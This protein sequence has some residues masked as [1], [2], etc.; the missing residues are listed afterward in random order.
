MKTWKKYCIGLAASASMAPAVLAQVP[1]AGAAAAATGV[2]AAPATKTL[3]SFL[4][5][6]KDQLGA[7]KEKLCQ[8][9]MGQMMGNG[10]KPMSALTGGVIPSFCPQVPSAADLAKPGAE[11]VAAKIKKEEAEAKARRAAVRYLGSVDCHYWPEAEAQLI[12]SLR[13]DTNECVRWEAALALAR[14]CCCT[15]ATVQALN[16][17]VSCSKEDGNPEETS[18]RVRAAAST[19]LEHCLCRVPPEPAKEPGKKADDP[20]KEEPAREGSSDKPKERNGGEK[21]T[22]AVRQSLLPE[23][24]RKIE[25]RSFQ[26]VMDDARGV[27]QRKQGSG[28]ITSLSTGERSVYGIL[29]HAI[30]P[31]AAVEPPPIQEV[32]VVQ[33]PR[34]RVEARPE[35]VV[36]QTNSQ[37]RTGLVEW[38]RDSKGVAITPTR[39]STTSSVVANSTQ[40]QLKDTSSTAS[41]KV[42]E[43]RSEPEP[44][45]KSPYGMPTISRRP[46]NEKKT[47]ATV[48]QESPISIEA[49][50]VH[51]TPPLPPQ[52][53]PTLAPAQPVEAS[54]QVPTQ[55]SAPSTSYLPRQSV[56]AVN[57]QPSSSRATQPVTMPAPSYPVISSQPT[58]AS[59]AV[60]SYAQQSMAMPVPSQPVAMNRMPKQVAVQ[61]VSQEQPVSSKAPVVQ[62]EAKYLSASSSEVESVLNMLR[63]HGL[64]I[65]RERAAEY[66]GKCDWRAHQTIVPGL[67]DAAQND[68]SLIVRHTCVR[69]LGQ[70]GADSPDVVRILGRMQAEDHPGIRGAAAEAL[71]RIQSGSTPGAR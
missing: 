6:S 8:T 18:E 29:A 20:K 40:P 62:A 46:V 3:W 25:E 31:G 1:A 5:I 36:V 55:T 35:P 10:L 14:G 68:P 71:Q 66:L 52:S 48:V 11:G 34:P 2:P 38:L 23:H 45:V 51:V 21:T 15:K 53:L 16:Y 17:T 42:V 19:A 54:P 47:T 58:P 44:Y 50:A 28:E 59:P 41:E 57:Y 70:M 12:A 60:S 64:S 37:P 27:L 39:G 30:K 61:T 32:R 13:A 43:K 69:T 56:P 24:Y 7:C 63:K 26:R 9:P 4:G 49:P 33:Q 22:S 67:L 65:Q